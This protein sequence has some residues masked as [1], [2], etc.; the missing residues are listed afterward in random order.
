MAKQPSSR[1]TE[2][3][4]GP[5]RRRIWLFRAFLLVVLLLISGLGW[6]GL[7]LRGNQPA[8]T[9]EGLLSQPAT[10]SPTEEASSTP[11]VIHSE[12]PVATRT[13]LEGS[14]VY[15]LRQGGYSHIWAYAA[16]D[17]DSIPLT[18]GAWDDRDPAVGPTGE[19]VAFSSNRNGPWDL[20]LLDMRSGE[21]RQLTSTPGYE[22]HPT[23]SPDGVW[24]AFE[25]YYDGDF[26]I[27]IL[28][29]NGEQDPIQLTDH[30]GSD[31]APTWDP[32][33]RRIAFVSDRDGSPDIFIA[34]LDQPDNRF[35]NL[36]KSPTIPENF[37]RFNPDSTWLAYT[38]KQNSITEIY[39]RDLTDPER[40]PLPLGAGEY[41]T[42]SPDGTS[43]AAILR[44][45][46]RTHLVRYA[47]EGSLPITGFS[48]TESV[49]QLDWTAHGL[50]GEV[51]ELALNAEDPAPL[52]ELDISPSAA[53]VRT[54]L[55][56]LPGVQAPNPQ[57]SDAVDEAFIAL[58]D[59]VANELGWDFLGNLEHAFL[60]INDPLPPGLSY[61]DWLYTGRAFA[62]NRDAVE[63]GFVTIVREDIAGQTYWRIFVHTAVQ[64]GTQG[65]PPREYPWDFSTR[66]EG[67][68][69]AY[70]QGGSVADRLPQ[71][72]FLDFT[73]LALDYGFERVPALPNWR[74]YYPGTRFN[75]FVH[76]QGLDW[77]DAMLELYPLSA[78]VTP[79]PFRTPTPTPTRTLRPTPTPWWWR[80]QTPTPS[81][82]PFI[83]PTPTP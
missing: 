74:T 60:G 14:L 13:T 48:I 18:S 24:I 38:Q 22:G 62:F 76:R 51:A 27:R 21:I 69:Q 40:P 78:I 11:E 25:A 65:E 58:K 66:F 79:T 50:P 83:P 47:V 6:Y 80:W 15:T 20:Y 4:A 45:A 43:I 8:P 82:T 23:W 36:T 7:K 46:Q 56:N 70:D 41:P 10:V 57:L 3:P 64:D 26:D 67:D 39:L 44:S 17:P 68:P 19:F 12:T 30:P 71:G 37:P 52:Y 42:W 31:T 32:A 34:N 81:Q 33:G 73:Q 77:L 1:A 49:H 72:Y 54:I 35:I 29:V 28:S 9:E 16:G 53:Q 59:R 63:A 5:S 61:D 55:V 75:E 2:P